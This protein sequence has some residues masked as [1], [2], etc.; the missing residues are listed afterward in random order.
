MRVGR[1][2]LSPM[3][4]LLSYW[5]STQDASRL[6]RYVNEQIAA[7][8]QEDAQRLVGFGAVPLQ[9]IDAAIDELHYCIQHL[10]FRG[11]EIGTNVNGVPIGDLQFDPFFE[12]C[13]ELGAAVFVHPLKPAAL[14]RLVGPPQLQQALAFPTEVGL[15]AASVLT[16]NL[17]ERRPTLRIAF[18]HGGGTLPSLLPRL[19]RSAQIFPAIRDAMTASP[20]EQAKRLFYD[21]LVFSAR[22]LQHL[23]ATVGE[24]QVMVGTDYP[25]ALSE[26]DPIAA[27]DQ[28]KFSAEAREKLLFG[29]ASRFLALKSNNGYPNADVIS[30][31]SRRQT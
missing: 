5:L 10:G 1:Q 31:P 4:E 17:I 3:P 28:A 9:S 18:S 7:L 25:F 22:A 24:S 12:A 19:E 11:V 14:D 15:A 30:A 29:N 8:V 26:T 20:Q 21:G 2:V 27:I 13:V 6:L 23:V 16:T